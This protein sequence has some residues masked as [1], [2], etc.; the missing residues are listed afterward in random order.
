MCC[1]FTVSCSCSSKGALAAIKD[2]DPLEEAIIR[3]DLSTAKKLLW[4][5]ES[6]TESGEPTLVG[7]NPLTP[8][9]YQYNHTT[10]FSVRIAT[11]QK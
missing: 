9:V 11:I 8:A 6:E 10:L 1:L 5:T 4:I 3:G 7:I 2:P